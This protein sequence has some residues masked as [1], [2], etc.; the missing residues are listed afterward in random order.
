VRRLFVCWQIGKRNSEVD[1]GSAW[2]PRV[3]IKNALEL[4]KLEDSTRTF[5]PLI[6]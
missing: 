6:A 4:N 1:W 5:S 2:N 3:S